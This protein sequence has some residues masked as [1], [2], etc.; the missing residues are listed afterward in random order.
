MDLKVRTPPHIIAQDYFLPEC[1][2]SRCNAMCSSKEE[3]DNIESLKKSAIFRTKTPICLFC[4]ET[5]DETEYES[6]DSD[7]YPD[8][9]DD[10]VCKFTK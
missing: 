7:V 9:P 3:L 6:V 4:D 5:K 2:C 10:I 1:I 8:L